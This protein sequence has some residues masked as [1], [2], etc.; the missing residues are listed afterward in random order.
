MP[1]MAGISLRSVQRIGAN[2]QPASYRLRSRRIELTPPGAER[3]FV[4]LL[5]T[6]DHKRTSPEFRP[7][8]AQV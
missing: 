6:G 2:D 1:K 5:R 8:T 3:L 7:Q 4:P